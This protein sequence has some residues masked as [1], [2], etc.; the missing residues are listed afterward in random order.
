MANI[1]NALNFNVN[2]KVFFELFRTPDKGFG[3]ATWIPV[4]E[5]SEIQIETFKY[6][7]N[8]Q[9]KRLLGTVR[10]IFTTDAIGEIKRIERAVEKIEFKKDCYV[11]SNTY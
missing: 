8:C 10:M 4:V 9:E 1:F 7:L 5:M 11:I 2:E 3:F 6:L